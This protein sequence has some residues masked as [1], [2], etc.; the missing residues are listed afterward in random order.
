MMLR[1][2]IILA[3]LLALYPATAAAQNPPPGCDS[4]ESRTDF[5]FWVG[6]WNVYGPAGEFAG[7]NSIRKTQGGCLIEEHWSGAS[8]SSG[9]SMNYYDP[10]QDAWRQVWMSAGAYIDYTGELNGDGA[11]FLEGG[12]FYHQNGNRAPFRGLWTPNDDGSVTQHFTQYNAETESW[13]VWFTGRYVRQEDD[14]NTHS[15]E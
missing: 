2:L 6:E 10:L 12:I 4:M 11:M 14:P 5:D 15:G 7:T 3:S 8:G 1:K 13:D 9:F